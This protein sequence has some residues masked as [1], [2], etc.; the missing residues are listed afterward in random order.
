[1]AEPPWVQNDFQF[2]PASPSNQ[3]IIQLNK[4][5]KKLDFKN[6]KL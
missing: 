3:V 2:A 1:V 4:E 5:K 6:K